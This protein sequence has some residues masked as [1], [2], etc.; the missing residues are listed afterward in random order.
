M[1]AYQLILGSLL[2]GLPLSSLAQDSPPAAAPKFYVGL[3]A[4]SG[5]YQ[6]FGSTNSNGDDV[7]IPVQATIGYQLRP[8]LAVQAGLTYSGYKRSYGYEYDY[9]D[10]NTNQVNY[11]TNGTYTLRA[12]DASLLL[13]YTLTRKA[14]HRFQADLVGG[15]RLT[16]QR[17]HQVGTD[18]YSYVN[19][20]Q[21]PSTII[22]YDDVYP[23][24]VLSVDLGPGFRYRF[25]QRL[26]AVGDILFNLPVT[27]NY[28]RLDS[29][30]SLGLRYHFGPS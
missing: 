14:A 21:G 9:T 26:E 20:G 15:L 24:N 1:T 6:R 10:T 3:A 17:G 27:S 13:R 19:P 22:E 23:Y 30:L 5:P 18:I 4:Y 2:L 16:H 12:F 29:S 8:R 28:H 11:S 25:G 7:N